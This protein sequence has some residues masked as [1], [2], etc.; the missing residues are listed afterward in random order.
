M[1]TSL[2]LKSVQPAVMPAFTQENTSERDKE[3]HKMK[4]NSV[5][6]FKISVGLK[7]I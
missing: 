4:M 2:F 7:I 6:V 5:F 1:I 3:M